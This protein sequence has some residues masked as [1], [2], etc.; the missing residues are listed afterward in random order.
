M[1][2]TTKSDLIVMHEMA[3]NDMDISVHMETLNFQR[4]PK[5]KGGTITVG[6]ASPA[7]DHLINQAAT[8]EVTHYAL[9]YVVN[10]EQFN[11][12]KEAPDTT[13][14]K[15]AKW[16]ALRKQMDKFYAEDSDA[17]LGVIGEAAA[18]AFGYL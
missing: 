17:D 3:I 10:S 11:K 7:F 8:G 2:K 12:L 16:D 14:D 4:Q 6:V 13:K 5:R 18:Q 1:P 15:A 9:L